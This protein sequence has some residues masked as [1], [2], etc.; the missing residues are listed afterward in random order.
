MVKKK[1][2]VDLQKKKQQF[3]TV[4][5]NMFYTVSVQKKIFTYFEE[6]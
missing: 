6:P 2:R 1:L 4:F 5:F 3:E